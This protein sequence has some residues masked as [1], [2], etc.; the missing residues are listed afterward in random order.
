[1]SFLIID[2]DTLVS[3]LKA[4]VAEFIFEN[5]DG[6]REIVWGTLMMNQLPYA[7]RDYKFITEFRNEE[8]IP[9][10]DV[11]KKTFRPLPIKRLLSSQIVNY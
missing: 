1:M 5:E 6:S 11:N 9:I 3:E 10:W 2:V 4:H 8:R 7:H